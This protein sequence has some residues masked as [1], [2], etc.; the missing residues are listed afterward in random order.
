MVIVFSF[1][2]GE[3][4]KYHI[5]GFYKANLILVSMCATIE[6]WNSKTREWKII[7]KNLYPAFSLDVQG[8]IYSV[9]PPD[10]SY[11]L[12]RHAALKSPSEGT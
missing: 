2:Y 10:F 11:N 4:I 7:F 1:L 9:L 8:G 6:E 12:V 3:E 5:D